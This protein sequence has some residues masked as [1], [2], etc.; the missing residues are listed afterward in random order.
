M[1]DHGWDPTIGEHPW[2]PQ[3]IQVMSPMISGA[4]DLRWDDPSQFVIGDENQ[5]GKSNTQ[6][7]IVGVNVYRSDN[8][9]RG[10]YIRLNKYPIGTMFYRDMTDNVVVTDELVDWDTAWVVKGD[11]P[12]DNRW[13][14]RTKN[15]PVVKATGQAV[16]AN[17]SA[18]VTVKIDGVVVP[19]AN[20]FGRNG[21]ITLINTR[22]WDVAREKYYGPIL[23]KADG[24]SVVQV[25]YTWNQNLV[26]AGLDKRAKVFYR[27]ATV[28]VSADTQ[29]GL[30]ETPLGW[31]P[32]V[33]LR[34]VESYDYI[35]KEGVRRNA[36]IL[37]QGGER[38]K[39]F[40]R[41]ISGVRCPCTWEQQTLEIHKQPDS[42]CLRCYGVGF[43]GGYDGPIDIIIAPDDMER[44]ISQTPNGRRME[45]AYEVWMGPSPVISQ[46]DF[47]IKQ[48]GERYSV[49]PVRRPTARGKPLQQ[50]F[51]I[52]YLDEQDI[53][54]QVGVGSELADLTYPETRDTTERSP[55]APYPDGYD[56][57]VNPMGTE[58][59]NI[60][61]E[62]EQRGRTRVWENITYGIL[63][64]LIPIATG[65]TDAVSW[66]L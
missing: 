63:P 2:P 47:I 21:E 46:R 43:I 64:W 18:D 50:H 51:N 65:A 61:D 31:C 4:V 30:V 20:V 5:G 58:K 53:R 3:N 11:N 19:A 38:C 16:H 52:G 57:Q 17:S 26:Q 37:Q 6:W 66:L 9:E 24:S 14:F 35:W 62:R 33:N 32:P 54:Y 44:R 49:G 8:G 41:K 56:R 22:V 13:M 1:A 40:L 60:P 12:N 27:L 15:C 7:D 42:R 25:S 45:H 59:D 48:T 29:S 36:W 34:S 55:D 28:A 39:L 23:P 10:P